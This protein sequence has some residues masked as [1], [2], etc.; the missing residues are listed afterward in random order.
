[1]RM[2]KDEQKKET[3]ERKKIRENKNINL[4]LFENLAKSDKSK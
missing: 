1:M 4:L 3:I 2:S